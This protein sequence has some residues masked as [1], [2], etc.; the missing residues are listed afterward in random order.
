MQFD[1]TD[2]VAIAEL[3][4]SAIVVCA[5][6]AGFAMASAYSSI[7]AVGTPLQR[8]MNSV[9]SATWSVGTNGRLMAILRDGLQDRN[10]PVLPGWD[11]FW[12]YRAT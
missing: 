5:L 6:L 12:L 1:N 4:R 7:N 2:V 10:E 8:W 11:V 9:L 3:H